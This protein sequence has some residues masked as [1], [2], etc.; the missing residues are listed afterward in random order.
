MSDKGGAKG[1][2]PSGNPD[3]SGYSPKEMTKMGEPDVDPQ[4]QGISLQY[5]LSRVPS[6]ISPL[7]QSL[8]P[9][10]AFDECE[11][12]DLI[13]LVEDAKPQDLEDVGNALWSAAARLKSAGSELKK[14]VSDVHWDGEAASSFREWGDRLGN[15]TK[16]LGDFVATVGTQVKAAGVGLGMVQK[17]VTTLPRSEKPEDI[18]KGGKSGKGAKKKDE[19]YE[20]DRQEAITQLNKLASYYSVSHD[21]IQQAYQNRPAFEAMPNV[22]IPEPPMDISPPPGSGSGALGSA[23]GG[24]MA[25]SQQP[26]KESVGPYSTDSPDSAVRQPDVGTVVR[27][28]S[29]HVPDTH[30]GTEIDSVAPSLPENQ[31]SHSTP[32][33]T[34]PVGGAPPRQGPTPPALPPAMGR[35]Q[36]PPM[37]GRTSGM[38]PI[39]GRPGM[40]PP[41][42]GGRGPN[43]PATGRPGPVSK[44][45]GGPVGEPV[46]GGTPGT[47]Q[48]TGR[49]GMMGVPPGGAG[50]GGATGSGKPGGAGAARASRPG[51]IVGG[52]PRQADG[53]PTT[54]IPRGTVIGSET[55]TGAGGRRPTGTSGVT[56]PIGGQPGSRNGTGGGRRVASAPG[57]VVGVPREEPS[58]RGKRKGFT[59]GGAGLV[60]GD[61]E[62]GIE[63]SSGTRS[64]KRRRKGRGA[65]EGRQKPV[66]ES[67]GTG[68]RG[69]VVPPVVE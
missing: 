20:A 39:T 25:L 34:D 55:A 1:K 50:H 64:R 21:Y 69:D 58:T 3:G 44:A 65:D 27:P 4:V 47:G 9:G 33:S 13:D 5:D 29:S 35:T 32:S 66:S 56:G 54:G 16:G 59:Q 26:G 67:E 45:I 2:E 43:T 22:G 31:L 51:G 24:A 38:P 12:N 57:G 30:I 63:G 11:L 18:P 8:M 10:T 49:P 15:H 36:T 40:P 14:H 6:M 37:T 48:A 52:T 62:E 17:Y 19:K 23:P 61:S 53:T 68:R 41:T 28:G 42:T 60:R 7:L 46:R